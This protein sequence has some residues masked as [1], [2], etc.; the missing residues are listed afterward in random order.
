MKPS[1]PPRF[2]TWLLRR[3]SPELR[4]DSL[5]GDLIEQYQRRRSPSWYWRQ[6]LTAILGGAAGDIGDHKLL[7]LRSIALCP[8][9]MWLFAIVMLQAYIAVDLLAWNW[10]AAH[11]FDAATV[12]LWAERSSI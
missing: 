10:T 8:L 3:L 6:V 4:R 5:I 12:L 1:R 2:A 9:L 11:R 7:A